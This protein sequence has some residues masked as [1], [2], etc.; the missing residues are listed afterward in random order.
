MDKAEG[1]I[2]K[3]KVATRAAGLQ[4]KTLGKTS[5]SVF[6]KIRTGAAVA[7]GAVTLFGTAFL[8]AIPII[9]QFAF[10][11]SLLWPLISGLFGESKLEKEL[12][13]VTKGFQSMTGIGLQLEESLKKVTKESERFYMELKV[14]VGVMNQVKSAYKKYQDSLKSDRVDKLIEKQRE[15]SASEEVLAAKTAQ[16]AGKS[17]RFRDRNLKGYV[18]DVAAIKTEMETLQSTLGAFDS[19]AATV[20]TQEAIRNIKSSPKL[21]EDYVRR[22]SRLRELISGISCR[23]Y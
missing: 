20:I 14:Q 23:R 1:V 8:N 21:M 15:L 10:A 9:G 12:K 7:R 2:A 22:A 11:I 4:M 16:F 13:T 17:Q 5:G 6:T 3:F 18:S 19:D